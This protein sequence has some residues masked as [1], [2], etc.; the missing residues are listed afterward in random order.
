MDKFNEEDTN[1]TE[2]DNSEVGLDDNEFNEETASELMDN[3]MP[4]AA[5]I[6]STN[7]VYGWIAI[8]LSI[9][10]F[11][12]APFIFAAAAIILG[13]VARSRDRIVLGNIAIVIGAISIII[14]LLFS[15]F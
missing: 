4:L 12:I 9:M 6:Q 5:D 1:L 15:L 2:L 8:G 7:G 13:F 10:S 11:F 14:R 3:D